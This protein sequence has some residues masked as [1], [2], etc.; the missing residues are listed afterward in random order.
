MA[1]GS[2]VP[3]AV[4]SWFVPTI[5]WSPITSSSYLTIATDRSDTK[6]CAWTFLGR[7]I[8]DL[9]VARLQNIQTY[10]TNSMKMAIVIEFSWP[11]ACDS[12]CGL[13]MV[14][15]KRQRG[16]HLDNYIVE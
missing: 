4:A 1:L 6:S 14:A 16:V 8:Q 3:Q 7:K 2:G 15:K 9:V 12:Q 10:M 5:A 11:P 13:T